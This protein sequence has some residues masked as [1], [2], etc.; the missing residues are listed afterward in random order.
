MI[1]KKRCSCRI[2]SLKA[3][4]QIAVLKINMATTVMFAVPTYSPTDLKN[5]AAQQSA[6]R[7]PE[8][9]ESEHYFFDLTSFW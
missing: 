8:L 1:Q 3:P 7:V 4:V 5:T 9:R 2:G 6:V